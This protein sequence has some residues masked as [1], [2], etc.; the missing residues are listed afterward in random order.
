MAITDTIPGSIPID[1]SF[2]LGLVLE[3]L[4]VLS[5]SAILSAMSVYSGLSMPFSF[6]AFGPN[7][8][9]NGGSVRART[10]DLYHVK[11]IS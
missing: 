11:V 10:G 4:I 8:L 5:R 9:A 3:L 2:F 6:L 1:N 7:S